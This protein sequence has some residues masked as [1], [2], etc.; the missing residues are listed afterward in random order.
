MKGE[1]L[2]IVYECG[3]IGMLMGD[4][5]EETLTG[6]SS[7]RLRLLMDNMRVNYG[8]CAFVQWLGK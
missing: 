7:H 5:V 3:V 1:S 8:V 2:I 4:S 6:H